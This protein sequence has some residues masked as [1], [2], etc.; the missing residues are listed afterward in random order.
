M[1]NYLEAHGYS[2][3]DLLEYKLINSKG[4]DSFFYRA[5]VPIFS[6]G[7]VTDLYGRAVD[8]S[9]AG[10]KHFYLY[11]DN[12]IGGIDLIDP[13]RVVYLFEA[14][15]DRLAAE[16]HGIDNGVDSGGA[17]KFTKYHAT[18]LYKK[19]V[20][21]VMVIYDGDDAGRSGALQSGELLQAA[22]I[23]TWIGELPDKMDPAKML[24]EQGK[25]AFVNALYNPKS[26]DKYKMYFELAKYPLHDIETYVAEM[27]AKLAVAT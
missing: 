22:G 6:Y 21:R 2:K 25:D 26:F 13:K 14:A 18:Q 10:I 3:S 7:K 23:Q 19:G 9:K 1:R 20:R 17:G 4:L 8:D 16:T 5:V 27:K 11:G 12:I 24:Q 15:I